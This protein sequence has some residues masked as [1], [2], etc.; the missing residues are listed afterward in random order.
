[1]QALAANFNSGSGDNQ[2][3]LLNLNS[4]YGL[5]GLGGIGNANLNTLNNLSLFNNNLKQ[6]LLANNAL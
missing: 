5:N 6:Q 1:M 4:L 3:N 2:N